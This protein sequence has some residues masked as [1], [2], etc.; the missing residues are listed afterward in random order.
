M[1]VAIIG[2]GTSAAHPEKTT[3]ELDVSAA[4]SNRAA[5]VNAET[6]VLVVP[7]RRWHRC[8]TRPRSASTTTSLSIPPTR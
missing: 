7:R 5:A 8:W 4:S 3:E 6:V 2:A 1:R